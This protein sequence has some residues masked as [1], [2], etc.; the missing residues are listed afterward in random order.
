MYLHIVSPL[1]RHSTVILGCLRLNSTRDQ[2][3]EAIEILKP[4]STNYKE[5]P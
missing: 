1:I 5:Q 4:M 2:I 3:A